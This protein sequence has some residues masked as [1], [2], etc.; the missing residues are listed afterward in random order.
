MTR[1]LFM[2]YVYWSHFMWL[3]G[4]LNPCMILPQFYSIWKTRETAGI[5]IPFFGILVFLQYAFSMHGFL[6]R[7]NTIFYSNFVAGSATLATL[8]SVVYHRSR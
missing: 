8:L 6:I 3:V 2:D 5:S 7:D 4:V 1:E